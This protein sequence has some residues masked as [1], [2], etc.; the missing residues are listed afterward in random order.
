M[1]VEVPCTYCE[2]QAELIS[3]TRVYGGRD[4]GMLWACLKCQAWVGVHKGSTKPLGILANAEL[5]TLKMRVHQVF[6][7]LWKSGTVSRTKAYKWLAEQMQIP[8]N[9]CHI[10]MFNDVMCKRA[11]EVIAAATGL[12]ARFDPNE[13]PIPGAQLKSMPGARIRGEHYVEEDCP[14]GTPPWE[15]CV[16]CQ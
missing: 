2:G 3:S 1:I 5:R 16:S 9:K 14:H 15:E 8:P 4:Y 11:L 13:G 6:D 7:R 12:K 10:G